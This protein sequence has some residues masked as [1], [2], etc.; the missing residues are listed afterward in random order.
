MEIYEIKDLLQ[1]YWNCETGIDEERTL[2]AYFEKDKPIR[3]ELKAEGALFKDSRQV[4]LMSPGKDFDNK[5]HTAIMQQEKSKQYIIIKLF[6]PA[7]RWVAAAAL[8]IGLGIGAHFIRQA[9][10]KT[11]FA[12]TYNDPNA[13]LRHATFALDKLSNVLRKGEEASVKSMKTIEEFNINWDE[14]DSIQAKNN[15][16]P[17]PY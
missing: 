7:L 1:K 4:Q 14:L 5:I 17:I 16:T 11:H 15:K 2:K 6:T 9:N 10:N 8:L 12:E 3:P 13:A